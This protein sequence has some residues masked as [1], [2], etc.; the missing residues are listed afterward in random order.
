VRLEAP[1]SD[2]S[3]VA[4]WTPERN[5]TAQFEGLV[6]KGEESTGERCGRVDA[7]S[8]IKV[9]LRAGTAVSAYAKGPVWAY[10]TGDIEVH[11]FEPV[12]SH[13]WLQVGAFPGLISLPE[14]CSDHRHI[15]VHARDVLD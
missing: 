9:M 13:E 4:G 11:A 7:P 14:G 8:L 2:G 1:W 5:T 3:K 6:R 12:G 10:V 15:W